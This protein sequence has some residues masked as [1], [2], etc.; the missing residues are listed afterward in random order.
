MGIDGCGQGN[1]KKYFTDFYMPVCLVIVQYRGSFPGMDLRSEKQILVWV[2]NIFSQD[3]WNIPKMFY[4]CNPNI[5]RWSTGSGRS[6]ARLSRL[7]WE[8]EVASS[9]LAA[10]TEK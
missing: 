1:G 10:P 8:Q 7:L 3:F 6:V 4:F 2:L 9:N 5:E